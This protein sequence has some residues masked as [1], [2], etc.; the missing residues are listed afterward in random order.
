MFNN[1][2]IIISTTIKDDVAMSNLV[3]LILRVIAVAMGVATVVLAS[4][5]AITTDNAIIL[6]GI[7]MVAIALGSLKEK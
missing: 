7:G 5:G 2:R 1:Q 4:L 3:D 6:L